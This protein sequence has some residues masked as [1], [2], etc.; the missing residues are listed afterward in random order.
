MNGY[1]KYF[2]HD[3][4]IYLVPHYALPAELPGIINKLREAAESK[5]R[6]AAVEAM[7]E[8]GVAHAVYA[9]KK[10]DPESGALSQVDMY[11]PAVLLDDNDF[12]SRTDAEAKANPGCIILASHAKK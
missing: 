10:Y 5:R 8:A 2:V 7:K 11:A 1:I 6:E 12:Y 3:S 9:V 4:S